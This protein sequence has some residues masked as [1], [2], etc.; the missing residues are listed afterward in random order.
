MRLYSNNFYAIAIVS[1][2]IRSDF[3]P[4]CFSCSSSFFLAQSSL[5]F[6]GKK[7]AEIPEAMIAGNL[8]NLK[9][10]LSLELLLPGA[11]SSEYISFAKSK[12]FLFVR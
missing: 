3:F 11:Y 9:R 8:S 6:S 1:S 7:V 5:R 2:S 4:A 10:D 12:P